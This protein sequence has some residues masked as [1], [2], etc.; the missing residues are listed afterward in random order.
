MPQKSKIYYQLRA[1]S[2]PKINGIK[3]ALILAEEND[4]DADCAINKLLCY[5]EN[6]VK[7]NRE[8]KAEIEKLKFI[9]LENKV[10]SNGNI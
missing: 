9:I 2:K 1:S 5:Q 7:E 4:K 10:N 3:N 6:L 8:L